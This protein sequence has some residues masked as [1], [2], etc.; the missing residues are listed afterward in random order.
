MNAFNLFVP[1]VVVITRNYG[2]KY[3]IG[4]KTGS[5]RENC[6]ASYP[7]WMN[8]WVL[9]HYTLLGEI[10][11]VHPLSSSYTLSMRRKCVINDSVALDKKRLLNYM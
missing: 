10:G 11:S 6:V 8:S 7:G 9:K 3:S 1:I 4:D 2:F 5:A